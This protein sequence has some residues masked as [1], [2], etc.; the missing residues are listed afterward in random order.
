MSA[1]SGLIRTLVDPTRAVA[2]SGEVIS[3]SNRLVHFAA[4]A[5][6][7]LLDQKSRFVGELICHCFV[8]F[9]VVVVVRFHLL[10]LL[11]FI[12]FLSSIFD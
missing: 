4:A 10:L 11:H 5:G 12:A 3:V 6:F 8:P 1:T 2:R 9:V 7:V